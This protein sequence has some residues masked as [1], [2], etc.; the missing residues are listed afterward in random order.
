MMRRVAVVL[1]LSI[2]GCLCAAQSPQITRIDITD[3]GVYNLEAHEVIQ[4]SAEGLHQREVA[5]VQLARQTRIIPLQKG[6]HFGFHYA[7]VGTPDGAP[8]QLRMVTLYPPGGL[9]NPAVATPILRSEFSV[10]RSIGGRQE[11]YHGVALDYDWGL[12]SGDWTLEI[13]YGDRKLASEV[14]TLV[15]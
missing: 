5:N 10:T 8:V 14:F 12:V 1:L 2:P 6:V 11:S 13:W 3:F 9:H 4:R 15:R 7:I